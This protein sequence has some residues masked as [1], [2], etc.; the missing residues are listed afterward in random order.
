MRSLDRQVS[1][2]EKKIESTHREEPRKDYRKT[3]RK[4]RADLER[5]ESDAGV[6]MLATGC[7]SSN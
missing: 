6:R 3:Q 2:L 7:R 5:L 1:N 4:Y